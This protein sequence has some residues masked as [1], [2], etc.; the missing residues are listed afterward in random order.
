VRGQ[1]DH[2]EKL[3]TIGSKLDELMRVTQCRHAA[4][5]PASRATQKRPCR[6]CVWSSAR[7]SSG[8]PT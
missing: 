7:T 5:L 6:W 2:S 3:D 1:R 4:W 8:T